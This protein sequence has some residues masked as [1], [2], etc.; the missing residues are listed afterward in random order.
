M[1]LQ[2][3]RGLLRKCG[4]KPLTTWVTGY[5]DLSPEER[6]IFIENTLATKAFLPK[7]SNDLTKSIGGISAAIQI[8]T[9]VQKLSLATPVDDVVQEWLS[10][11]LCMDALVLKRITF[12]SGASSLETIA[13]TDSVHAVRTIHSLK[14]RLQG[15]RR[16][17]ALFHYA[18]PN[19]PLVHIHVALTSD[20]ADSM[21]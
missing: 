19:F 17:Y 9:D 6:R 2:V 3:R 21:R 18:N 16:C 11:A 20:L 10:V 8:R 13:R 7:I 5:C 14:K 12:D 4:G 1:M 15:S